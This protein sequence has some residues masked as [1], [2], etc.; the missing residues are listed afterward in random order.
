MTRHF[1]NIRYSILALALLCVMALRVHAVDA[2]PP[3]KPVAGPVAPPA[4]NPLQATLDDRNAKLDDMTQKAQGFYAQ[5]NQ[6]SVQIMDLQ[7]QLGLLQ[8]QIDDLKK[9]IKDAQDAS[10]PTPL[11]IPTVKTVPAASK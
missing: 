9:S 10:S 6:L 7:F 3:E 8:K 4:V 2:T 5:R 1:K 11:P